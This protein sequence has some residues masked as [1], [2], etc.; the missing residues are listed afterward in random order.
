MMFDQ[1]DQEPDIAII[2]MKIGEILN[3]L[4]DFKKLRDEEISR[5]E[6][7]AEL[8]DKLCL[9][10]GYNSELMDIFSTLFSPIEV[11]S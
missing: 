5:K 4:G 2:Q 3:V 1:Q 10:Y 9:L 11:F 8:K 7:V 6:Y